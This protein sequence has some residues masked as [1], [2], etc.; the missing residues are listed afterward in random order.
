MYKL[1]NCTCI[2][3]L[4]L[5]TVEKVCSLYV[6]RK[7]RQLMAYVLSCI[8]RAPPF[9]KKPALRPIM[10]FLV[11][12][13]VKRYALEKC[14]LCS[15]PALPEDPEVR[16]FREKLDTVVRTREHLI[17]HFQMVSQMKP[18]DNVVRVYCSHIFHYG[19]MDKYMNK[20]PFNGKL[21]VETAQFTRN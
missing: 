21:K 12:D 1:Y 16:T 19:C 7:A 14:S 15:R 20:P 8:N 9:T 6:G 5:L 3:N 10:E 4:G 17:F 2:R 18:T 11:K 13:S